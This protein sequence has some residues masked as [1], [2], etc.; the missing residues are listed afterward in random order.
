M[1]FVCRMWTILCVVAFFDCLIYIKYEKY[2]VIFENEKE[3][4]WMHKF[5]IL[6]M[7][8]DFSAEYLLFSVF[9]NPNEII[10]LLAEQIFSSQLP[11]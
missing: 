7:D 8:V 5:G 1:V 6:E 11:Q 10:L 2:K 9:Q 4:K 3:R